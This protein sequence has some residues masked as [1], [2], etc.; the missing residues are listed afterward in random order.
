MKNMR[1]KKLPL[2]IFSVFLLILLFNTQA[3]SQSTFTEFQAIEFLKKVGL[4]QFI[5]DVGSIK[6]T[7]DAIIGE[8]GGLG[9]PPISA[10]IGVEN[11][12]IFDDCAKG[13][14]NNDGTILLKANIRR[15]TGVY[16]KIKE[17]N[18]FVVGRD[19]KHIADTINKKMKH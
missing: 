11:I 18:F 4:T 1:N 5:Q 7:P 13:S 8:G 10:S 15:I 14:I 3:Y 9:D 12:V 16:G 17:Q 6:I 2:I 19:I